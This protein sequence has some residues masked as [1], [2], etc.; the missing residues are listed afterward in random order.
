MAKS[1]KYTSTDEYNCIFAKVKE[2][3]SQQKW[4]FYYTN[5]SKTPQ[6][7]AYAIVGPNDSPVRIIRLADSSSIFTAK[8]E[9]L[10]YDT[11]FCKNVKRKHLICTDSLS[12]IK[13]IQNVNH[14]NAIIC[15]IRKSLIIA[16][17]KLKLMW[18]P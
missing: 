3:F 16:K 8:S 15:S 4:D 13:A 17:S 10:L 14:K 7:V 12:V 5:G 1:K 11:S 6:A 18:I 9:T 2:T